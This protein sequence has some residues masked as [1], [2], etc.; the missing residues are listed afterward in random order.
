MMQCTDDMQVLPFLRVMF[1]TYICSLS[2]I[3]RMPA[4]NHI[5][6][7]VRV[8]LSTKY[9]WKD[10]K[11][12]EL[13]EWFPSGNICSNIKVHI[14]SMNSTFSCSLSISDL[15]SSYFMIKQLVQSGWLPARPIQPQPQ[16]WKLMMSYWEHSEH[17]H[18]QKI[19]DFADHALCKGAWKKEGKRKTGL[20][21]KAAAAL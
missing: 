10:S 5:F 16:H 7:T 8:I 18:T 14:M 20:P 15:G 11:A 12:I 1:Q 13:A 6:K 2:S 21:W 9:W 19:V 4:Q 3:E 17:T